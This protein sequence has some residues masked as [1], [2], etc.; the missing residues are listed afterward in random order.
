VNCLIPVLYFVWLLYAE[1]LFYGF[2]VAETL[3]TLSWLLIRICKSFS[4]AILCG[5]S[6][7]RDLIKGSCTDRKGWN[8][9]SSVEFISV[10]LDRGLDKRF[11]LRQEGI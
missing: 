2:C 4:S 6:I 1:T 9:R 10:M 5:V 3:L 8:I 7:R 11:L